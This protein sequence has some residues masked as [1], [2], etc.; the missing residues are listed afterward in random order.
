ML[1]AALRYPVSI[2]DFIHTCNFIRINLS[3]P[4][5]V[6]VDV[7]FPA[8]IATHVL[9]E[10]KFIYFLFVSSSDMRTGADPESF[11]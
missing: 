6:G 1:L 2:I 10:I 4:I 11:G 3:F 5:R 7:S 8:V 9:F